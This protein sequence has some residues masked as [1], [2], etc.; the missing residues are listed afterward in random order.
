M[1]E[2]TSVGHRV[3]HGSGRIVPV[4]GANVLIMVMC[5]P[6][7]VEH[8]MLDLAGVGHDDDHTCLRRP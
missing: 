6:L 3:L 7:E 1:S 4:K 5:F 8:L 2:D